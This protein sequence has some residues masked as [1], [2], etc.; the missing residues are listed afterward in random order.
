MTDLPHLAWPYQ[1]GAVVEQDSIEELKASAAVIACTPRGHR[2]DDLAF[3]VTTPLF[4]QRPLDVDRFARELAQSDPRIQPTV[5]EVIGLREELTRV[6]LTVDV[7][8]TVH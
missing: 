2:D 1:L 4:D 8:G 6:V 7:T 5:E 3:G